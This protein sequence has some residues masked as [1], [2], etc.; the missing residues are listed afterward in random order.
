[1]SKLNLGMRLKAKFVEK[2]KVISDKNFAEIG[3][4]R[5]HY[6]PNYHTF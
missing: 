1:M 3:D 5:R 2:A 6:T 4:V